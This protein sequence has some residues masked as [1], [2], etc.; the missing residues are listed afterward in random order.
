MR[1]LID[2]IHRFQAGVFGP[3]RELFQRLSKGQ[4]P[5]ALFITCSDSRVEPNLITQTKPGDL[6]I[7]RNAG[8]IVP[9]W[10]VASGEA[11]TI[12]YAIEALGINDI[13][14]CG[15]THCGAVAGI[16]DPKKVEGLP[17]VAHWLG[18]AE[19]TRRVLRD[20]YKDLSAEELLSTAV[21]EH[22]LVQIENLRT[23]PAVMSKLMRGKLTLH[24]W[25]YDIEK[26]EVLAFDPAKG[27]F[28]PVGEAG[29]GTSEPAERLKNR[30]V[31]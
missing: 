23:H 2:G 30:H 12:E 10:G 27:Q 16:V 25:V 8:N 20:S 26:G 18:H 3:Q 5:D 6:F 9:P 31:F 19:A 15:H 24:A 4:H 22:V 21:K 28:V 29:H 17:A 11:C 13:I 14:V 7:S 1:A